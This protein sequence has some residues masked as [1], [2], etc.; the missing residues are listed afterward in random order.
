MLQG[1]KI[2]KQMPEYVKTDADI[3][4]YFL[5]NKS[6]QRKAFIAYLKH[7]RKELK[8]YIKKYDGTYFKG[9]YITESG[10]LA[11]AHAKGATGVKRFFDKGENKPDVNGC[12]CLSRLRIFSGY[13]IDV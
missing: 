8:Q 2:D 3:K 11:A 13:K 1:L 10:I 12:T 5:A 7:N 9:V 4:A 6:I